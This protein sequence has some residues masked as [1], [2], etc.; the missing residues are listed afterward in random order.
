MNKEPGTKKEPGIRNQLQPPPKQGFA[1]EVLQGEEERTASRLAR[2]LIPS[3]IPQ[4]PSSF[5]ST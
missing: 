1:S 3:P 4:A 2:V 5:A